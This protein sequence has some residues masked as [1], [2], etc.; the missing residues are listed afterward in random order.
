MF[1]QRNLPNMS[2]DHAAAERRVK[3]GSRDMAAVVTD[4][5]KL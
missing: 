1:I 2:D 4:G 5:V 3:R